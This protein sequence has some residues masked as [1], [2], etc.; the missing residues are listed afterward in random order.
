LA[1]AKAEALD[2]AH[3]AVAAL[4][5]LGFS[6]RLIEGSGSVSGGGGR[7]TGEGRKGTRTVNAERPCPICGFKTNPPHDAR[8]HRSQDPKKAFTA[9][10]L[11]AKGMRKA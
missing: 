7:T 11:D 3:K 1:E 9:E 4:N 8:A 6:Y 10:E 5:D 2:A